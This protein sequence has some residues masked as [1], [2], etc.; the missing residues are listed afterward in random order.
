[1][2]EYN[3]YGTFWEFGEAKIARD[4]NLFSALAFGEGGL[5]D[6][7]P[8][9]PRGLPHDHSLR[10]SEMFFVE[11]DEI[12]GTEAE[13]GSDE[14]FQPEKIASAWGDWALE[15]FKTY[16][17]LPG[18]DWH[19]PSWLNFNELKEALTHAGLKIEEQSPEFRAA[20]AAMKVL[21]EA[22]NAEKVR[23]VFWFD[24]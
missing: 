7:M 3:P 12:T 19:T 8:Y 24:G 17:L 21:S 13:I 16:G 5:T 6:N 4:Y 1:V 18:H 23:L 15:Q 20:C 14:E 22:Y 11:A 10:V 9:P 2:I